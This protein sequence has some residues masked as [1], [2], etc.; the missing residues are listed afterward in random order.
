MNVVGALAKRRDILRD[1]Q[2]MLVIEALRNSEIS[3][4][5]G[6]NQET[7]LRHFGDTRWG[8][9]YGTLISIVTMFSS[10]GDVLEIITDDG[11]N[12]EQRCEANNLLE[13]MNSFTFV[14]CLHLMRDVLGITNELSQALQRK[15]QDIVNA[16]KLVELC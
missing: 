5:Q 14:F 13:L 9:H 16:M 6:L 11:S 3:S 4:G 2:A 12:S 8:S 15:D 1:K 7:S 10:I